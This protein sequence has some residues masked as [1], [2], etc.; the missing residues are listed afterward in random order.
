M[1]EVYKNNVLRLGERYKGTELG[2]QGVFSNGQR[3]GRDEDDDI[4]MSMF[5]S[6]SGAPDSKKRKLQLLR[7]APP[8]SI[9]KALTQERRLAET[10][11]R[12]ALCV[13]SKA[14]LN[15]KFLEVAAGSRAYLRIKPAHLSLGPLHCEIVPSTHAPSRLACD[16]DAQAEIARFIS[17]LQYMLQKDNKVGIVLESA[18]HFSKRSHAVVDIV[19]LDRAVA[20]DVKIFFKQALLS[21]DEE[22]S[23]HQ[24]LIDLTKKRPLKASVPRHFEYLSVEWGDGCSDKAEGA[25]NGFV[26]PVE[27]SSTIGEDFN[28]DVLA[29][30]L[31]EAHEGDEDSEYDYDTPFR[32]RRKNPPVPQQREIQRV[33]KFKEIF[34]VYDWTQY[35]ANA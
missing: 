28:L 11:A 12:C 34:D 15:Q 10:E 5:T 2:G 21:C 19:P 35:D 24:K 9:D 4:D 30:L 31:A 26:H 32:M 20:H 29:G 1:D 27:D 25:T 23:R 8:S 7:G 6:K 22:F 18:V 3:D 17:C 33:L 16:D 13:G 14:H